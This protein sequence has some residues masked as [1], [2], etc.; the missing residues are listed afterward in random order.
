M[1]KRFT[2]IILFLLL[3]MQFTLTACGN[4]NSGSEQAASE[5]SISSEK[6]LSEADSSVDPSAVPD[7]KGLEIN[8]LGQTR[9]PYDPD[10]TIIWDELE[11]RTGAKLNFN[12][13]AQSDYQTKVNS[14]LASG[15]L[16][17][18]IFEADMATLLNEEAIIPLD[19]LLNQYGQNILANYSDEDY[20]YLRQADDGKI[21]H[22][23]H[24]LDY[25]YC[26]STLARTDWIEKL[27]M[28]TPTTY[29]DW[30][31]VWYAMKE[32][33]CNG[34]GDKQDEIPIVCTNTGDLINYATMFD[35]KVS[36]TWWAETDQ[37]MISVFEHENFK[38]FL[39]EMRQ[40]YA[41]GILD[42]EFASR[43]D[44]YKN[45]LDS[46]LAGFTIYFAE[47]AQ[48]TTLALQSLEGENARMEG[49][50]PVKYGDGDQ[51]MKPRTKVGTTGLCI[52]VSA[53]DKADKIMQFYNYVFSEEGNTLMNYGIEGETFDYV[54][55]KPVIKDD[56]ASGSFTSARAAGLVCTLTPINFLGDAYEQLL[57]AGNSKDNLD[58]ATKMFYD[59]LYLNE[60]YFYDVVPSFNTEE[61]QEYGGTLTEKLT[62]AF[63]K[64]VSGQLSVD[65]FWKTYDSIKEEGWQ[66]VIDAQVEAYH[67]LKKG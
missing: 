44:T 5:K 40:L 13:V 18:V 42:Q 25:K 47:R 46:G 4:G 20:L 16:P 65:D 57:L 39:E 54:E 30:K 36:N 19:D 60:P 51:L 59:A 62:T 9:S 38:P 12:W 26:Y 52:T 6:T 28:T 56:I 41:D 7:L 33:D 29:E 23:P 15:S 58:S 32:N 49:V 21:Y 31:K 61:Y 48:I 67:N 63:A 35:I 3:C 24:V 11:K 37:G 22:I 45:T 34:N 2:S 17:D 55:N 8:F 10:V 14:I 27:G 50:A 53:E 66:K 1:K 64:C 43:T